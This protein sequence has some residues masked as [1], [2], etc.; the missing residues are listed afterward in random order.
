M[1]RA[2]RFPILMPLRYRAV[3]TDVLHTGEVQN[4]SCTGVLFRGEQPL[5]LSCT[6]DVTLELPVRLAARAAPRIICRCQVVRVSRAQSPT[7]DTVIAATIADYR[8]AK[9]D[10]PE[11]L[12]ASC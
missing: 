3:G 11:D 1:P 2:T 4:I 12:K 9:G 5:E 8:F 6:A 7:V 10:E